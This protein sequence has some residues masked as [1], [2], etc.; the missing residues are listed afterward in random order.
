MLTLGTDEYGFGTQGGKDC[1]I[2]RYFKKGVMSQEMLMNCLYTV[3]TIQKPLV[4][5]QQSYNNL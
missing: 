3:V 1:F 2:T 4:S 5:Y